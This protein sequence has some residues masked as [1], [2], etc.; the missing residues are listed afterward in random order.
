MTQRKQ[1]RLFLG[2]ENRIQEL[3]CITDYMHLDGE[4]ISYPYVEQ[5]N[6]YQVVQMIE[7][8]ESEGMILGENVLARHQWF[9]ENRDS[10]IWMESKDYFTHD[11]IDPPFVKGY[12][13]KRQ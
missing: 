10:L 7:E 2:N 9:A 5:G 6:E 11:H 13:R 1:K 4:T 8:K 3:L 12:Y